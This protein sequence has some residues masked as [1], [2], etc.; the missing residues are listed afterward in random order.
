MK[1]NLDKKSQ[2]ILWKCPVILSWIMEGVVV[3]LA[4][5]CCLTKN[6]SLAACMI[7]WILCLGWNESVGWF[8]FLSGEFGERIQ[9]HSGCWQNL[10]P[11]VIGLKSPLSCWLL[12]GQLSVL[13]CGF[14]HLQS[15][16][17]SNPSSTSNLSDF[18][19][20]H[21]LE[22]SLP[23][24]RS[25]GCTRLIWTVS[26]WLTQSQLFGNNYVKSLAR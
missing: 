7:G 25:C 16:Y 1:Q 8:R 19:F 21:Q 4:F 5:Y 12:G 23:L 10:V 18:F 11:A 15:Q 3:V 26:F 17:L 22:Y 9:D 24:N 2:E 20:C 14:F 13:A 6:T